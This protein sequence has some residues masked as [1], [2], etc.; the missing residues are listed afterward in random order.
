MNQGA[1]GYAVQ[2]TTSGKPQKMVENVKIVKKYPYIVLDDFLGLPP[3]REIE[4]AI[5]L[6]PESQSYPISIP[7]Y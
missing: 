2:I 3:D 7:P 5:N 4:F 1:F 6:L